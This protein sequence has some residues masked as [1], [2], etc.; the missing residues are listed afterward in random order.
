MRDQ[1]IAICGTLAS[2]SGLGTLS[3][4]EISIP[5]GFAIDTIALRVIYINCYCVRMMTDPLD[6]A[7]YRQTN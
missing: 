4:G 2:G 1:I 5:I 7:G 3:F 6:A